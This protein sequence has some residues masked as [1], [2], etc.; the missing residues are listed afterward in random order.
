MSS[1]VDLSAPVHRNADAGDSQ[2]RS[3]DKGNAGGDSQHA[4]DLGDG[5]HNKQ[6]HGDVNR[7]ARLQVGTSRQIFGRKR[8]EGHP[9]QRIFDQGQADQQHQRAVRQRRR[10]C[11]PATTTAR[12]ATSVGGATQ[13]AP[14]TTARRLAARWR[15][16]RASPDP[17]T[18]LAG[19]SAGSVSSQRKTASRQ[20]SAEQRH[21]EL[22]QPARVGR[23]A[24]GQHQRCLR[25][26]TA[27]RQPSRQQARQGDAGASARDGDEELDQRAVQRRARQPSRQARAK[28]PR[29]ARRLAGRR[30]HQHRERTPPQQQRRRRTH[31]NAT[32]DIASA[33]STSASNTS[34]P[35]RRAQDHLKQPEEPRGR[36][37]RPSTRGRPDRPDAAAARDDWRPLRAK[38]QRRSAPTS[39]QRLHEDGNHAQPA[40]RRETTS[41]PPAPRSAA[42]SCR[43]ARS[44]NGQA[45]ATSDR[46][47]E[48]ARQSRCTPRA[49]KSSTDG[50]FSAAMTAEQAVPAASGLGGDDQSRLDRKAP[51]HERVAPIHEQR[52]PHE[53]RHDAGADHRQHDQ[54]RLVEPR[55]HLDQPRSRGR[56]SG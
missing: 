35:V 23:H 31:A 40:S 24:R 51:E 27:S 2:R 19:S 52:F 26:S 17:A 50:R 11:R 39:D 7:P 15:P 37:A 21:G 55:R 36:P 34:W 38:D 13:P 12:H 54:Q 46:R 29:L 53:H 4:L 41:P 47:H 42:G 22:G 49:L 1:S 44:G 8:H 3:H 43:Q 18:Q 25:V 20:S 30:R 6:Q 56:S 33:G 9:R 16:R 32:S 45:C 14:E 28:R 5:G 48:R 10:Q